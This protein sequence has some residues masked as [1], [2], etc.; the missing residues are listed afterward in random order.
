MAAWAALSAGG[1]SLTSVPTSDRYPTA[2][3]A[4]GRCPDRMISTGHP[5]DIRHAHGGRNINDHRNQLPARSVLTISPRGSARRLRASANRD[6]IFTSLTT[7]KHHTPTCDAQRPCSV[8]CCVHAGHDAGRSARNGER[9]E[10]GRRFARALDVPAVG[11]AH[12]ES[13]NDCKSSTGHRTEANTKRQ[14]SL[15][16]CPPAPWAQPSR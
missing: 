9:P 7:V 13:P 10:T 12:E 8:L 3:A 14:D 1:A 6:P 5:L 16:T 11:G 15:G 2:G 4:G